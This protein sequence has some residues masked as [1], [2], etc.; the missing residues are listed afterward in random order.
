M[1]Y[2]L[3]A[4]VNAFTIKTKGLAL[5]SFFILVTVLLIFDKSKQTKISNSDE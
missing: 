2:F 3:R 1:G 4:L 5:M